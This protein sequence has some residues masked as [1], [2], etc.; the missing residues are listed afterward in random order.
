[1]NIADLGQ[2]WLLAGHD[3][4][5]IAVAN[6]ALRLSRER[7]ERGHE[8][9]AL[10]L[11]GEI[12]ARRDAAH[13]PPTSTAMVDGGSCARLAEAEQRYREALTLAVELEMR[14]L[15][16]HCHLGLG[17]LDVRADKRHDALQ[18]FGTAITMYREM[19]M[20]S[21]L[22]VAEAEMQQCV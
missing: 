21:W 20:P 8:A 9:R 16:A 13:L 15:V 1:V 18:H 17:Q 7:G 12:A 2:A 22:A 10:R 3:A 11:L 5:A 4:Q 6:E 14:P 19:A